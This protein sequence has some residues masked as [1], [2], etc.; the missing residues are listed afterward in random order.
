MLSKLRDLLYEPRLKGIDVD[1]DDLVALH[2]KIL[3]EKPMMREVFNEFYDLLMNL[4]RTHLRGEGRRL[5]IGAGATIFKQRYPEIVS[6]DIKRAAHLDLVVDALKMPFRRESLRAIYGINCFH[7]FPDPDRFFR[8]L[9]EVLVPGGGC[10]LI[11]PYHG[12]VGAAFYKRLFTTEHF[13]TTQEEWTSSNRH[14]M[15]GA[16]QALSYI[17]FQRDLK[18]FEA[19]Y[20]QLEVVVQKPIRSFTRY[21]LSGGLN[22]RQLLPG[23]T[24]P[25]LRATES[26]ITPLH[27]FLALHHF[28]VI[29]K[30]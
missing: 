20:P 7:H 30:R 12:P 15:D 27:R 21:V 14:V 28:I 26:A 8:E 23:V 19:R 3:G 2:R 6:S 4:D 9:V 11:E 10:I 5:E 1:S 18:M 24:S 22:F 29:R 25:L 13:D 16:N 17:V